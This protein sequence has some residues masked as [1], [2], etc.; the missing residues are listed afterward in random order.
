VHAAPDELWFGR[1]CE[2]ERPRRVVPGAA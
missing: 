1:V 2:C